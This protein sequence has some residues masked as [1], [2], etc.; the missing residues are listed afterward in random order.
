MMRLRFLVLPL[1]LL[2]TAALWMRMESIPSESPPQTKRLTINGVG[3]GMSEQEVVSLLGNRGVPQP[4]PD[5]GYYCSFGA[6]PGYL[7]FLNYTVV[8]FCDGRVTGLW[9]VNLESDGRVIVRE[10][11]NDQT[12][13]HQ[14]GQVLGPPD[15]TVV[16]E[17]GELWL[18]NSHPLTVSASTSPPW[19]FTLGK[20]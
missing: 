16:E 20:I 14:L 13:S 18:Y 5:G 11:W 17:Y 3:L 15:K 8:R 12:P 4:H 19:V 9:G 2:S 10:L 7:G 1:L 6:E